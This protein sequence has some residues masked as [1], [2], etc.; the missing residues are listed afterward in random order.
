MKSNIKSKDYQNFLDDLKGYYR[1][2]SKKEEENIPV[3]TRIRQIPPDAG[4]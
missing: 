4:C 3:G 1:K 2:M